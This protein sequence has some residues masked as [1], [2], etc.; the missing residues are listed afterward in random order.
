[1]KQTGEVVMI[2]KTITRIMVITLALS[3]MILGA[4]PFVPVRGDAGGA[5][6]YA[7]QKTYY[8]TWGKD[9]SEKDYEKMAEKWPD[10]EPKRCN[11]WMT[12][13][14]NDVYDIPMSMGWWVEGTRNNFRKNSTVKPVKILSGAYS[15]IKK[16]IDKVK[17]GDIVFFNY[18]ENGKGVWSHVGLIG[19]DGS[20]WH[21]TA[22][23]PGEKTGKYL[24]LTKWMKKYGG[25]KGEHGSPGSYAEV[26]RVLSSFETDDAV[27]V[28]KGRLTKT[29][30][31]TARYQKGNYIVIQEKISYKADGPIVG[32]K[33]RVK[34]T[35]N[36]NKSDGG[37]TVVGRYIT[38]GQRY[39]GNEDLTYKI[40]KSGEINIYYRF[41]I[42]SKK[43][44][45][46]D[47]VT[48]Q[49]TIETR[50]GKRIFAYTKP[51][52][53]SRTVTFG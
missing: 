44:K 18:A 14:M 37:K 48:P 53:E 47:T 19:E 22:T 3:V 4:A 9:I 45:Q 24:T 2:R 41:R 16:N 34:A 49:V 32:K 8:K 12:E 5:E 6:A 17:P 29:S 27:K 21:C 43:I 52:R 23:S 28:N 10:Y 40:K 31:K 51:G 30:V 50:S 13:V 36:V 25:P 46:E 7:A 20:L 42:S 39:S 1:M 15:K 38:R 26:W 35:L 33:I 11:G